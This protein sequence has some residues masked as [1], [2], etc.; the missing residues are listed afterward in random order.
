[1]KQQKFIENAQVDPKLYRCPYCQGSSRIGIHNTAEQLLICHECRRTFALSKG[2]PFAGSQYPLWVIVM[3][4]TLLAHGCPVP[5]IVVAFYIDERTVR[6]WLGKAGAHAERVHQETVGVG[7]VTVGQVQLDELCV[8][9][10][11]GKVW[12][13]TAM[14]VFSRLFLGGAVSYQRDKR[15][16]GKVVDQVYAVCGKLRQP[17]LFAVDG[18]A[19]Y[20]NLIRKRFSFPNLTGKVGRPPLLVWPDLHI[21]QVV[22]SYAGRKLDGVTH[23]LVHGCQRRAEELIAMTQTTLGSINTAY[24]ERLNATFRANLP[25]LARR[26]RRP[27]RTIARLHAEMF[28]AGTVYNFCS[29]HSSLQAT[30]AMAA[31]LTDSVWSVR[32]LLSRYGPLKQLQVD[33]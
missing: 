33:L 31:G 26:T 32:Q 12:M 21:V 7:T 3:V 18:F 8:N 23:K 5:A 1:M 28:W 4:L 2:T 25:S 19:A 29:V 11:D 27:A 13:A 20:P 15:L 6:T 16:I 9:S 30:P 10:Q 14:S 22:K 24:I 17:L